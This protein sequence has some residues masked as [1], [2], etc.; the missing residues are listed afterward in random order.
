MRKLAF[1]IGFIVV[2]VVTS[3]LAAQYKMTTYCRGNI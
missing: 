2:V 1:V 3:E